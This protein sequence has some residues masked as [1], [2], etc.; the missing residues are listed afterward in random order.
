MVESSAVSNDDEVP[1]A[2]SLSTLPLTSDNID[3]HPTTNQGD[4]DINNKIQGSLLCPSSKGT[5]EESDIIQKENDLVSPPLPGD[6]TTAAQQQQQQQHMKNNVEN[7]PEVV[8][9]IDYHGG[10]TLSSSSEQRA[11]NT[12]DDGNNNTTST[13][14]LSSYSDTLPAAAVPLTYNNDITESD[15][16]DNIVSQ[17]PTNSQDR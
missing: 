4:D 3:S 14:E 6:D 5:D 2:S 11:N 17:P 8:A 12:I 16:E 10:T 13:M 15:E 9:M 1:S 7:V